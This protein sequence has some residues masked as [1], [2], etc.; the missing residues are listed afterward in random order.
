MNRGQDV[1]TKSEKIKKL[2]QRLNAAEEEHLLLRQE[3]ES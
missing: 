3:R 2:E 1:I